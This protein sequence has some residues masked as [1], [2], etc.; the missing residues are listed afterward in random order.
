MDKPQSIW[1]QVQRDQAAMLRLVQKIKTIWYSIDKLPQA[2][3]LTLYKAFANTAEQDPDIHYRRKI[4]NLIRDEFLVELI[5]M[6]T[7]VSLAWEIERRLWITERKPPGS[8]WPDI[9]GEILTPEK[10]DDE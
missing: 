2:E 1:D 3:L 7:P 6:R 9:G 10:P 5:G 4:L 8:G